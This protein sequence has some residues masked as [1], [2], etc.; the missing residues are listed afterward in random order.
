MCKILII[1]GPNLNLLGTREPDIYGKLSI[2]RINKDLTALAKKN[3]VQIV[4][5]QSNHEGEIVDLIQ[6]AKGKFNAILINPA[7]YTHT[8]VAIR[9][10]IAAVGVPTVEIHLSNIYAREEFRRTSLISAVAV[11]QVSGFGVNSYTLG[12]LAAIE[13]AKNVK[14]KA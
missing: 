7:A 13:V 5:A 9:D 3:K 4:I 2:A 14:R 8:S 12:L 6:K 11:G 10:A 1:H